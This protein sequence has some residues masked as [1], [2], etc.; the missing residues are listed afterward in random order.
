V[1]L[2]DLLKDVLDFLQE[3]YP[4]TGILKEIF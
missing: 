4:L 2:I 1:E 3:T